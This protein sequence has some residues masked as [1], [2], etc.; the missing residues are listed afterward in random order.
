MFSF[1]RSHK[2]TKTSAPQLSEWGHWLNGSLRNGIIDQM[3]HW[4]NGVSG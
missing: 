2:R 4:L 3:A 1:D